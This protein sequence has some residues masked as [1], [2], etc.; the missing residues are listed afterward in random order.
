MVGI[1]QRKRGDAVSP[2]FR[3]ADWLYAT[4]RDRLVDRLDAKRL[5]IG[6]DVVGAS[7]S[8]DYVG[9]LDCLRLG[10]CFGIAIDGYGLS[11]LE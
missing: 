8:Q 5:Q 2:L 10:V 3:D 11:P 9:S 6:G 4:L 1:W 7:L